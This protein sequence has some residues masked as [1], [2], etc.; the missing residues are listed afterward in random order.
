VTSTS[1]GAEINVAFR[2]AK[3]RDFRGAKGDDTTVIESPVLSLPSSPPSVAARSTSSDVATA[4]SASVSRSTGI[5]PDHS[6]ASE[7][8]PPVALPLAAWPS[9]SQATN[10]GKSVPVRASRTHAADSSLLR[11]PLA[12]WAAGN[13]A[14]SEQAFTGSNPS[15]QHDKKDAAIQALDAVLAQY[16]Q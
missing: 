6:S 16:G 9:G 11:S 12:K 1:T 4:T 7:L 3:E 15:D 14:W 13:L 10:L 8:T 2:S 5:S